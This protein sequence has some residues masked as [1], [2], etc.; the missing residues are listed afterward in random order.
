MSRDAPQHLETS[1]VS[2]M[3][4][5]LKGPTLAQRRC[6][7]R[8]TMLFKIKNNIAAIIHLPTS[9]LHTLLP[10]QIAIHPFPT[11]VIQ[12]PLNSFTFQEQYHS[13]IIC[14]TQ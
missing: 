4:E 7:L 2:V 6:C 10:E 12:N 13:G 8:L 9:S 1:S 14:Q 3:M 5:H 11:D